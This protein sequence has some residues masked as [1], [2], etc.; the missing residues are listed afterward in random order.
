MGFNAG[1]AGGLLTGVLQG[2]ESAKSRQQDLQNKKDLLKLEQSKI[3]LLEDEQKWKA[4]QQPPLSDMFMNT[5]GGTL[6]RM[7]GGVGIVPGTQPAA[8][9][10]QNL[11]ESI[12][13]TSQGLFLPTTDEAG[14][15]TGVKLIPGTGKPEDVPWQITVADK[16]VS[17]ASKRG[18]KLNIDEV[19][20]K[21][22]QGGAGKSFVEQASL[23]LL[24]WK[25]LGKGAE[26]DAIIRELQAQEGVKGESAK[27][28]TSTDKFENYNKY[29]PR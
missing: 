2:L 10:G 29:K 11:K 21:L 4:K 24:P 7:G 25:L 13:E 27:G 5:P 22:S 20:L 6:G 26:V 23:I 17:A 15:V 16:V 12:I 3:K 9:R 18:I 28:G 19:L 1:A 14:T 8:G